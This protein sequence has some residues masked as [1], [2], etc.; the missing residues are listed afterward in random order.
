MKYDYIVI[1]AG[2]AGAI[3]ATRLSEDPNT[4]VLLLEAGPDYPDVD[5]L[6][7]EVKHGYLSTKSIWDSDHNWQFK[8]RATDEAPS[9]DVPRGRVTGG[10]S[11]INGQIFI[12]GIPEDYDNWAKWGNDEWSFQKLVPYFNMVETDTTYQDDPGDFHGASGPIICHR[13]PREEWRQGN[14]AWFEA[15]RDYG[16]PYCEDHNAPGTTGVGPTTLNNPNGIRWS[17]A[18]GYLGLSRHRLNLT[19]RADV[20]VKR[21]LFDTSG[22]RP[23][24]TGVE[25]ASGEESFAVEAEEVI[26]SAGAI[27]SPQILMLSGVGPSDHL[28]QH[29]IET[30]IDAPGVGQNLADHPLISILWATKPEVD[31]RRHVANA[32][33]LARYT[34][35]GSPLEND[36]IVYLSSGMGHRPNM[37]GWDGELVGLGANLGLNLAHAKGEVR[38]NSGDYRDHPYL[39]YNLL[40]NDEDLRRFRDGVR[41]VV[42]MEDHPSMAALIDK[43]VY[44]EDTDLESDQ[45]L[46]RW[47]LSKVGTGHHVSCTA[48]MGPRS[49]P[50]AVVDQYGRLYGADRLRVADASIMPEC[51]RA[52]INVTVL[53]LAERVSDFIKQGK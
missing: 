53:M 26:L 45:S 10:S 27:G 1:G 7:E 36:M 51:V 35:E 32:Q 4:S 28:G 18:I 50:M 16:L 12:R 23:R 13:F 49:D 44:P 46:D 2:S 9:I 33:I 30:L 37:G 15:W 17:T 43:R 52:N 14:L 11:A 25:A 47:I 31:L 6:P 48:K 22:E 29:G 3:L 21:I 39:D 5:S 34:A 24:A 20:T 8:A 40:A 41:L 38:L 42:S 19:I